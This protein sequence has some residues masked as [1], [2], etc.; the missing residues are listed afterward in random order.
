VQISSRTGHTHGH[1][2]PNTCGSVHRHPPS[3][4][5]ARS[6]GPPHPAPGTPSLPLGARHG[7]LWS[8]PAT[9]IAATSFATA[10]A[11]AYSGGSGRTRGVFAASHHLA[12]HRSVRPGWLTWGL[13]RRTARGR[14]TRT[15][16]LQRGRAV[17]G[18]PPRPARQA[19]GEPLSRRGREAQLTEPTVTSRHI[20]QTAAHN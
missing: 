3:V 9:T 14:K 16:F 13:V 4:S 11:M 2:T 10:T 6:P 20:L 17:S 5:R 19:T 12:H 15:P 1:Q 18:C 8:H 7:A